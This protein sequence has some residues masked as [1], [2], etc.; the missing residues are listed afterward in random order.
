MSTS[1]IGTRTLGECLPGVLALSVKATG[2]LNAKIA[3]IIAAQAQLTVNPPTLAA[4]LAVAQQIVVSL[5]AAIAIGLPTVSLQAAALAQVL[6]ALQ[7]DLAAIV[8]LNLGQA[9]VSLY[10]YQGRINDCSTDNIV[11]DGI[12]PDSDSSA[13]ILAGVAPGARQAIRAIAGL[14]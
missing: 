6:A 2:D 13:I 3:G 14:I 5:Q 1:L 7:A 10:S 8:D 11:P 12:D 9:G 4:N